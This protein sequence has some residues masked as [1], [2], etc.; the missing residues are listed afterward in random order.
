MH[1]C[2]FLFTLCLGPGATDLQNIHGGEETWILKN[3]GSGADDGHLECWDI[4]V[5][6]LHLCCNIGNFCEKGENGKPRFWKIFD[7]AHCILCLSQKR[8][9]CN[10]NTSNWYILFKFYCF[11][12]SVP[13]DPLTAGPQ[14]VYFRVG[15]SIATL[16]SKLAAKP[17]PPHSPLMFQ[18]FKK[19]NWS[20]YILLRSMLV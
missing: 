14:L 11:S 19:T 9:V 2:I 12:V 17:R 4:L 5:Q 10:K 8:H 20:S 13:P 18:Y 7:F 1:S 3:H 15:F 16:R 6:K